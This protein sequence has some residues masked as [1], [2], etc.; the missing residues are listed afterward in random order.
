MIFTKSDPCQHYLGGKQETQQPKDSSTHDEAGREA[1]FAAPAVLC[2]EQQQGK[3]RV[4][5]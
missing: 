5:R 1:A 3:D 4:S 2:P